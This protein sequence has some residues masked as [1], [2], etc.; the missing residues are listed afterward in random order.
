[1]NAPRPI[2]P[3]AAL[4][5]AASAL[6]G[7]E[8]RWRRALLAQ[9]HPQ[10]HDVILE[11]DCGGG[12]LLIPMAQAAQGAVVMGLDPDGAAIARARARAA[13]AG[14]RVELIH[15]HGEDIAS[16]VNELAPSKVILTLRGPAP[17]RRNAQ[18]LFRAACAAM[19]LGGELHVADTRLMTP[20]FR[21]DLA[22]QLRAAGFSG[23][24]E[25]ARFASPP[26][27]T[28]LY[29]ARAPNA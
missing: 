12:D 24:H 2:D 11:V 21:N 5:Q 4:A 14:V 20:G 17:L 18:T 8:P 29:C 7:S 6:L 25:T 13:A 3:A 28:R 19:R 27:M 15:G 23:V 1:M 9:V 26:R 22:D 10:R 16:Y